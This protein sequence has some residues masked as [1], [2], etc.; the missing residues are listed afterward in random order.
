MVLATPSL[1]QR[2]SLAHQREKGSRLHLGTMRRLCRLLHDAA[3]E[4]RQ[5]DTTS[6]IN[7]SRNTRLGSPPGC[8][9]NT[10]KPLE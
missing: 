4:H 8:S 5:P 10:P 9:A 1:R 7:L 6:A 2:K 3:I